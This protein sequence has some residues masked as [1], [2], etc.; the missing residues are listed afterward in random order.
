MSPRLTLPVIIP[1]RGGSKGIPR[2]NARHLA[3]KPLVGRA[4][5]TALESA[6]IGRVLV[7]TDDPEIKEISKNYGAEVVGRPS[8]ISGD[9]ASSE[10]ALLHVLNYLRESE[11]YSPDQFAFVQCTSPLL[12]ASDVDGAVDTFFEENA[13][14]V[15]SVTDFHGFLWSENQDGSLSGINHDPNE[16]QRRQEREKQLEETGG[17]YVMDREGFEEAEH[18]FFGKVAP[19]EVPQERSIEVDRPADLTIAEELLRN[20]EAWNRREKLPHPIEALV[21]DFDGVFTDNKVHV[22]QDRTEMVTCHRGDGWGLSELQEA[23]LPIWVLS[24]EKNQVVQA[25]CDK[26]DLPCMHGAEDKRALLTKWLSDR[27]I[28]PEHVVYL[29]NDINDRECLRLVGCG[30]VVADAHPDVLSSANLVLS[31]NG[32]Q[33]AVRELTDLIQKQYV[34]S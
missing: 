25:R 7:S 17:V 19:Y 21:L 3:G 30:A 11:G 20:Q 22:R 23:G 9:E 15:L 32:G 26:L 1:A 12:T 18:R 2:K 31:T 14:V 28:D 8:E 10:S 13:D 6:S 27:H 4:I 5:D 34:N 16:R 33:G 29:G 24:T